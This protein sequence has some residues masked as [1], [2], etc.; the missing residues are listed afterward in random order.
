MAG[1]L[2]AAGMAVLA[3]A[4]VVAGAGFFA[5]PNHPSLRGGASAATAT[6]AVVTRRPGEQRGGSGP[7]GVN[8]RVPVGDPTAHAVAPASHAGVGVSSR[9]PYAPGTGAGRRGLPAPGPAASTAAARSLSAASAANYAAE[10]VAGV[11]PL[12]PG[13]VVRAHTLK[14]GGLTRVYL[15]IEPAR[16]TSSLPVVLL[17]HGRRMTPDTILHISALVDRI[18]PAVLVVPAGWDRSWNAG[19]CCGAAYRA[20]VNDVTFLR[21]VMRNVRDADPGGRS[22]GKAYAVGF[23]NGGRLAYRLACEMPGVFS[24][25]VA[26]EAV[27][28]ERC[29]PPRRLDMTIVAQQSDPLLTI[30]TGRAKVVGGFTE[31]TVAAT[32]TRMRSV[33]HCAGQPSATDVGLAVERTWSC[34]GGTT[35]RYVWYPSGSH[36]W[37]PSTAGTP[38][39]TDVVLQMLHHGSL[40][41][42]ATG[43]ESGPKTT[44]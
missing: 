26:I 11:G 41:C 32:V 37:R 1:L 30:G 44:S 38:G 23:S 8:A 31:P 4:A 43:L 25:F 18:G 19:D 36:D 16:P 39:A 33:D 22:A 35:L 3:T 14:T 10:L 15:T 13:W 21:T 42:R 9:A 24:G 12:P 17:L 5:G 2:G 28:V 20:G 27:P 34:A 6:L 7:A 29:T 40:R